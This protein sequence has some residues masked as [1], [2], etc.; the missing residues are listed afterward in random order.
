MLTMFQIRPFRIADHFELNQII[1]AVCA[2][3]QWMSTHRFEPTPMWLHA[4]AEPTCPCHSL[5]VVEDIKKVV[6]WC[7]IFPEEDAAIQQTTLGVGLLPTYRDRG[8]GTTLVRRSLGWARDSGHCQIRLTTHSNN[9]RAIHVF[10]RCGFALTRRVG[11]DLIE[12]TC[13]LP[14]PFDA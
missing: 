9:A 14:S 13:N 3:R 7:R 12:M 1:D 8:I 4:M 5:L 10:R 2:E 11:E 6:G